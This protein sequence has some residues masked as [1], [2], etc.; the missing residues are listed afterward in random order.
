[1]QE[2]LAKVADVGM[3]CMTSSSQQAPDNAM[4]TFAWAAPEL[5]LG[6]RYTASL[7]PTV[8]SVY[9]YIWSLQAH[10]AFAIQSGI[11]SSNP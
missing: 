7:L 2:G 3:A 8:A 1:M 9:L 11:S 6:E 10:A 5:L 4:G